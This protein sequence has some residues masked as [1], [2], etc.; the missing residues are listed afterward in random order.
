MRSSLL[1]IIAGLILFHFG[2]QILRAVA[3]PLVFLVFMIPLPGVVFYAVTFPLQRLAAEQAAWILETIGIPVLLDGNIIH[4]TQMSL[5][6]TEACSGIRSLISL[7]AGAAASH[8]P[9]HPLQVRPQPLQPRP[10]VQELRQLDLQLRLVRAGM[11]R[12]YGQDQL[13]A[14]DHLDVGRFFEVFCSNLS[15]TPPR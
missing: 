1:V 6:V 3:F 5:G 14:V 11:G 7:F 10:H 15:L 9:F 12:K 13:A 4:L 8:R 2:S